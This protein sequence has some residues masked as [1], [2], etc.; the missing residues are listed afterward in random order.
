MAKAAAPGDMDTPAAARIV[1]AKAAN[2]SFTIRNIRVRK[3]F[4]K[5]SQTYPA[6]NAKARRPPDRAAAIMI[7]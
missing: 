6:L 7:W 2:P 3:D 1:P 4:R 5:P